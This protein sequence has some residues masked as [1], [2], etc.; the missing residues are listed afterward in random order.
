[1]TETTRYAL[2]DLN[3][4]IIQYV[5]DAADPVDAARKADQHIGTPDPMSYEEVTPG[6]GREDGYAVFEA[7]AGWDVDGL[8]D[9]AIYEAI[10]AMEH[11]ADVQASPEQGEAG[12]IS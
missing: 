5:T 9:E 10:G 3:A 8:E 12:G 2:C 4:G 1:M 7:P 6:H 11:V